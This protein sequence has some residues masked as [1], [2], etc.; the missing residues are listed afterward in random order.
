MI[1]T[2]GT[3][4]SWRLM[5]VSMINR[6]SKGIPYADYCHDISVV[7]EIESPQ[8]SSN[9]VMMCVVRTAAVCRDSLR[10]AQRS[11]Y[12]AQ[13]HRPRSLNSD[14]DAHDRP[15]VED[16]T[17]TSPSSTS[18]TIECKILQIC[19]GRMLKIVYPRGIYD[20]SLLRPGPPCGP[21]ISAHK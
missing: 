13:T 21:P 14:A 1:A 5:G 10:H 9:R 2:E 6:R 3:V 16:F 20:Q 7:F 11:Y 12:S 17:F 4:S 19:W 18:S 15:N 8:T